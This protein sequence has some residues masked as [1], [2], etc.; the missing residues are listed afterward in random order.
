M[1]TLKRTE[2]DKAEK[3]TEKNKELFDAMKNALGN[4]VSRVVVATTATDSPVR[5]I[6]EGPI[7]F[8]MER[9]MAQMPNAD[10]AP[11]ATR[12]LEINPKH[13]VFKTLQKAHEEGDTKKVKLYSSVLYDQALLIENLPI[14]DPVEYAK[15]IAK[16]MI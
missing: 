15:N 13:K 12:V 1:A 5:L 8:D 2:K 9:T 3:V 16:L 6:A 14:E 4:N 10:Q 11:K 7:S